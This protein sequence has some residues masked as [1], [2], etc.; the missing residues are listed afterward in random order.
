MSVKSTNTH[1]GTVAVS[2]HWLSAGLIVALLALGFRASDTLDPVAKASILQIH[3]VLGVTILLLTL[4]RIVWWRL[5]AKPSAIGD[6]PRWQ[7]LSAKAVHVLFYIVI[8]GMAASGIG[9]FALSGAAP[10]VFGGEGNLPDFNLYPPRVPHGIGARA[11]I[12]LL[13]LHAG[14]ALY[15]HFI[16]R[17]AMLRRMWFGN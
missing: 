15:H 2:I 5:D 13:V 3:A 9:M 11:M 6:G 1:Y 16:K 7:E 17:D 10:I 12:I 8:I 14:A 4:S